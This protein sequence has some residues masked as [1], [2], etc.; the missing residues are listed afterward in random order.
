MIAFGPVPSRRLGQS[1]GVNNIPPKHCSYDCVYCQVG[2][3]HDKD[4][5]RRTFFAPQAVFESVRERVDEV[6]AAG[7]H[8]DYL[9][10]VPDGEPSLDLHLAETIEL[11]RPLGIKI[12]VISNSSLVAQEQLVRVEHDDIPFYVRKLQVKEG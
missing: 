2:R 8:I 4:L 12:A 7:G 10:I 9:S 3:T 1:L 11:L 6:R 5:T